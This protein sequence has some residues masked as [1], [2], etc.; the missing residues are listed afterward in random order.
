MIMRIEN[1]QG[2]TDSQH[3]AMEGFLTESTLRRAGVSASS[4]V[5]G[6]VVGFEGGVDLGPVEANND[7]AGQVD[8]RNTALA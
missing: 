5:L 6:E 8:D 1:L 2:L 4:P 7:V 3:A